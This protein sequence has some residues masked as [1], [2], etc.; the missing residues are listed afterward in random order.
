MWPDPTTDSDKSLRVLIIGSD[1]VLEEEF[2][3]ALSRIP[4]RK[5][6]VY[7]VD[8]HRD[9]L[10]A[11]RRRQPNLIVIEIDRP[12]SETATLSRDLQGLVP[13]AAID[14]G[15]QPDRL[16]HGQAV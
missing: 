7:S 12:T 6:T 2:R 11:A 10:E 5:G 13:D 4:D 15:F 16:A 8:T 9:A 1:P 3:S 14:A